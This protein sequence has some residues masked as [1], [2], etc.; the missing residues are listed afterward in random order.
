MNKG[1]YSFLIKKLKQIRADWML[2]LMLAPVIANFIIFHY[3][4][5]YGLQIAF[6][7]YNIVLG[8]SGSPWVGFTNFIRFFTSIYAWQTIRNTLVISFYSLLLSPLPILFAL[9]LNEVRFTTMKKVI[10]TSA[11]LPYFVSSVIMVGLIKLVFASDGVIN[12]FLIS[13]GLDAVDFLNSKATFRSLYVGSG[14]WK[15]TGFES[16]IFIAAMLGIDPQLYEAAEIDGAGRLK[17]ILHITLPGIASTIIILYIIRMGN[18]MKVGWQD[19]YL[20]QNGLNEEVSEV[21]QTFVYKR[22]LIQ[23]DY[24]YG[25]AVGMFE[26]VIGFILVTLSNRI[27]KSVSDYSLF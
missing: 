11:Y 9:L 14:V 17:R 18:I 25:G 8:V 19:I 15:F 6:K 4:P 13:M 16:I 10:Q 21:I 23:A 27:A 12:N 2:Y 24:G 26:S 7:R 3:I 22:G 5:M 1:G 20:L